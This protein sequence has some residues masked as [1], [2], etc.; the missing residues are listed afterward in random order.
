LR[1]LFWLV[2]AFLFGCKGGAI[3]S[4]QDNSEDEQKKRKKNEKRFDGSKDNKK[5]RINRWL[6]RVFWGFSFT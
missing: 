6:E 3:K 1:R 5:K 2:V 4:S